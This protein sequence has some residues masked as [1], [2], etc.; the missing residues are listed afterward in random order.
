MQSGGHLELVHFTDCTDGP[1]TPDYTL[2][3]LGKHDKKYVI[4]LNIFRYDQ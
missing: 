3:G 4:S 1:Q 2:T